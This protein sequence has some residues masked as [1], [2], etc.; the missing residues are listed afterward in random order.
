M[1]ISTAVISVPAG[2]GFPFRPDSSILSW[3]A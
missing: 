1:G 3:A 2:S